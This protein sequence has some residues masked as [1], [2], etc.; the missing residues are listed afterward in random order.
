[1]LC[2]ALLPLTRGQG[3]WLAIPL[4]AAWLAL[5]LRPA[6]PALPARAS[7]AAASG[8][9]ALGVL[10]YFAFFW[11]E[12]GHPLAGF[13]VQ[14]MFAFKNALGNL[15]DPARLLEFLLRPPQHLFYPNNSVFDKAMMALTAL[16]MAVGVRRSRDPFLLA[17]WAAFARLPVLMGEGGSYARHALL[18]WACFVVAAGPSLPRGPKWALVL[19]MFPLQALL[20]ALF[21]G[22]NWVG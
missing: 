11:W 16:T 19:A 18:A 17:A 4:A 12:Y 8:G 15:L 5:A 22:N 3:L 14:S 7:L 1:L 2:A 21:G 10:A 20:A 13:H 6:A 9:Y